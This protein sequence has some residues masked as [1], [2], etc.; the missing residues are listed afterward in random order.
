MLGEQR[1]LAVARLAEIIRVLL[2]H[3]DAGIDRRI[4]AH[5]PALFFLAHDD[6]GNDG[7]RLEGPHLGARTRIEAANQVDSRAQ[8]L[9]RAAERLEQACVVAGGHES[10][11]VLHDL[12]RQCAPWRRAVQGL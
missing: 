7:A 4:D 1:R 6:I 8:F 3:P 5:H 12:E 9:S 2:I 10:E 11:L